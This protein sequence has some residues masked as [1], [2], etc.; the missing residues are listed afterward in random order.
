MTE[1]PSQAGPEP[2]PHVELEVDLDTHSI[3]LPPETPRPIRSALANGI[4]RFQLAATEDMQRVAG[5][6]SF[7]DVAL[8]VVKVDPETH[9]L[10][11]NAA[12]AVMVF[13][14]MR[15][16]LGALELELR[17]ATGL[18]EEFGAHHPELLDVIDEDDE[19]EDDPAKDIYVRHPDA[20][21]RTLK[22]TSEAYLLL[23]EALYHLS[24]DK[25]TERLLAEATQFV[26][27]KSDSWGIKEIKL[28]PPT[29]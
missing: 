24:H 7:G 27:R 14:E 5:A 2:R 22:E 4:R 29:D 10:N 19:E 12:A 8:P 3:T 18:E 11:I 1:I 25:A 6:E 28:D 17:M 26:A 20:V 15:R 9:A 16:T 21:E 23:G 13:H